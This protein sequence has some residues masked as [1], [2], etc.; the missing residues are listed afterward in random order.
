MEGPVGR[1]ASPG[2]D[3]VQSCDAG[4]STRWTD[5]RHV[6]ASLDPGAVCQ[7]SREEQHQSPGIVKAKE[8]SYTPGRRS[9]A[10]SLHRRHPGVRHVSLEAHYCAL[11]GNA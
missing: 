2:K 1:P 10:V 4:A 3:I 7:C 5:V 8:T 6:D 9:V 11:D